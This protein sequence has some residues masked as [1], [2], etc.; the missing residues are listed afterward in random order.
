MAI[1]NSTQILLMKLNTK[2]EL[3]KTPK[4]TTTNQSNTIIAELQ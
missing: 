4:R 3:D 2:D 1:G